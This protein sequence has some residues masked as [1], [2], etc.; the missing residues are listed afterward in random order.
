[1]ASDAMR[2]RHRLISYI[3]SAAWHMHQTG[4]A[5]ITPM[6]YSHPESADA[7]ECPQQYWFGSELLAAPFT[8]PLRPE[9]QLAQQRLWLPA[10]DWFNFFS[11]ERLHGNGWRMVY[12]DLTSIPL[13]ARAGAIVP[14]DSD[15]G[16][17]LVIF[18]GADN[19]VTLYADDGETDQ[20]KQGEYALTTMKQTW[21]DSRLSFEI[22]PAQGSTQLIPAQRM[23]RLLVRGIARPASAQVWLDET[24]QDTAWEY[25]D[26][27]ETLSTGPL[28]LAPL[29]HLRLEVA[30]GGGQVRSRR[31]ETARAY[32]NAFKA[33]TWLKEAIYNDLP[34]L[35]SGEYDLRRYNALTVEQI[36][37]LSSV[38]N[39]E[40]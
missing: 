1:V 25:D 30:A 13:W 38:L 20:Y 11:G 8:T 21:S 37:A 16:L 24:P 6:Y 5:L 26:A 34:K 10:G 17:D 18:P 35:F 9:T 19:S 39:A 29:A 3:Y 15:E 40:S 36:A 14:L 23:I 32:L 12:G 4:E 33:N 7:Y 22:A 31:V 27:T 28:A 2:L